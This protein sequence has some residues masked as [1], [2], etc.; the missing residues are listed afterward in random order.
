[1]SYDLC[2]M[3]TDAFMEAASVKGVKKNPADSRKIDGAT[4]I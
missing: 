3:M 2:K 1:M 4:L